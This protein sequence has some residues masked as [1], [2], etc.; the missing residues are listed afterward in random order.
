[1]E[2]VILAFES[3]KAAERMRDVIETSGTAGCILCHSAAEVKRLVQKQHVTTVICGYK[4]RD[5][6][7]ESLLED[8]PISCAMLVVA[9]QNMLDM[10]DSDDIFKLAAPVTRNDLL[11]SV[12]MLLQM[13]RRMER[14]VKP[15]QRSDKEQAIVERAK[16]VLADRHGMTEEQA[17]R[18][19]Q[20]KSMD[21]GVKLAQTAQMILDGAWEL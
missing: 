7:A 8:L 3:E 19:L 5:E 15:P 2:K 9:V 16:A 21:S 10:I 17:H 6:T 11:S 14:F 13:G 4:L 20:K 18:F 12:R 1:M